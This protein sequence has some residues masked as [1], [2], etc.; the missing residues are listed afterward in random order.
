MFEYRSI[1]RG[2]FSAWRVAFRQKETSQT[3]ASWYSPI[4]IMVL[5]ILCFDAAEVD[6]EVYH[7]S[8]L[9]GG[10]RPDNFPILGGGGCPGRCA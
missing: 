9:V 3:S 10:V 4:M 5:V 6:I 1:I 7:L 2:S 8:I